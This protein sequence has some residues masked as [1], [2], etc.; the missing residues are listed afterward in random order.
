MKILVISS[1][2][3]TK[4]HKPVNRLLVEDFS[5]P[6]RLAARTAELKPYEVPAAKM[7]TGEAHKLVMEGLELLRGSYEQSTV[8]LSIISAGYGLLRA[9]EPIVPYDVTFKRLGVKALLARRDALELHRKVGNLI[10]D[11]ELV[12]FLL[13]REYVRAL[14]ILF[15][16]P[17]E[18]TQIILAPPSWNQRIRR[19][20]SSH[21]HIHV[22]CTEADLTNQLSGASKYNLK[23]FL[24][25]KVCE[26]VCRDGLNLFEEIRQNPQMIR[27]IALEG[28]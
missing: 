21:R 19:L 7:Y 22:V 4:K 8:D 20:A 26:A 10:K 3:S 27:D 23:G 25:K 5:P 9:D 2:S 24:F 13:G 11:Y 18:A 14:E 15:E 16:N 1:C 17:S 12:F 6:K 28:K